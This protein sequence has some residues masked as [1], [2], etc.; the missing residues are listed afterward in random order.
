MSNGAARGDRLA[1]GVEIGHVER[2]RIGLAAF[3][4]DRGGGVFDVLPGAG[5]E[6]DMRAGIG[7]RDRRRQ[8]DAA[9]GAGHQ[10][11]LAVEA[12]GGRGRKVHHSAAVA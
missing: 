9:A 7:Q 11:A 2:Q 4:F 10:R 6:R 3:G 8:P 5:G 12:K 1:H